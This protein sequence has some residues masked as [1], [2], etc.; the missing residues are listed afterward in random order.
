MNDGAERTD[1]R[2]LPLFE[3]GAWRRTSV[4][5][6]REGASVARVL[7]LHHPVLGMTYVE[8]DDQGRPLQVSPEGTEL[9]ARMETDWNAPAMG[10]D[11]LGILAGES[12]DLR[13]FLLHRLDMETDPPPVLFHTLPWAALDT[14]AENVLTLLDGTPSVEP[15]VHELRHWFAPAVTR[16]AGPLAVLERGMREGRDP[17]VLRHEAVSLMTGLLAARADRIPGSTAH[18]LGHLVERL[19]TQDALLGHTARVIRF[20]LRPSSGARHQPSLTLRL[21]SALPAAA[22]TAGT[23]H[24]R[25]VRDGPFE[26]AVQQTSGGRLK[27][28]LT[29]PAPTRAV[30]GAWAVPDGL[31]APL[32]LHAGNTKPRRFWVALRGTEEHAQGN[33][34]LRTPPERFQLVADE[35]AVP[36]AA[37]RPVPPAELVPSLRA[38]SVATLR[39]WKQASEALPPDHAVPVALRLHREELSR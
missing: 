4:L 11:L 31:V 3:N 6:S 39:L 1:A 33:V 7:A 2:V 37:L 14:V 24:E 35:P 38:S 22:R 16:V 28:T 25:T 34:T 18:L 20:R 9:I 13:Y 21:E 26:A 30:G 5:A 36:F 23:S 29:M 10:L 32:V 17:A 8:L 15:P 12:P 19:S 27:V